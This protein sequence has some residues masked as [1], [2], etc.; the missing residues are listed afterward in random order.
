[1]NKNA[2]VCLAAAALTLGAAACTSGGR[3]EKAGGTAV[4]VTREEVHI[5][6][7]RIPEGELFGI[8]ALPHDGKKHPVV[9]ASHGYNGSHASFADDLQ[10]F[11]EN[12]FVACAYDFAGGS[13]RSR[14]TGSSVDMSVL[15]EKAD[16]YAV[17]AYVR[18]LECVDA[19]RVFLLGESQGGFVSALVADEAGDAIR[20]LAL[21]YPALCIPDD[22]RARF[23]DGE[24]IP[25]RLNFWGLTIGRAYFEAATAL[26]VEDVTG[27][28]AG[29]V[30]I[31]HGDRD[32]VV[33][34]RYATEA[35]ARYPNARLAVLTGERHGFSPAAA[36]TARAQV[37]ALMQEAIR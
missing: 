30:L 11:A 2:F 3:Q 29:P 5:P 18:A 28:Y 17:I 16:L 15:T 35:A 32:E 36:K 10:F 21:Y 4:T 31:V 9:I 8:L 22:W 14:S 25:D 13:T 12:G 37:L 33:P 34:L 7:P 23:A 1:M 24:A 6:N 19:K 26:H 27:H 20:G